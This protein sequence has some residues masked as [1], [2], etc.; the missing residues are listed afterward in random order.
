VCLSSSYNKHP[1]KNFGFQVSH[2]IPPSNNC[3]RPNW[4]IERDV[5]YGDGAE[6]LAD[7]YLLSNR[8]RNPAIIFIHGGG[9]ISGDKSA[10]LGRAKKYALAGF[11]VIAINY[12]LA[13]QDDEPTRW[14]KQ[15]EDVQTAVR[16][17]RK[18]A[19]LFGIDPNRIAAGGDSSGGHLALFLGA[20]DEAFNG[21]NPNLY[22]EYSSKVSVVLNEFGPSNLAA[23]NL[24]GAISNL[25]LIS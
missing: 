9:W 25:P 5:K 24:M 23:P 10:Y 15:L 22:G 6:Q 2:E 16:W 3:I 20:L 19:A 1:W 17:V 7:L 18:N 12:T 13:R 14:P 21:T 8:K 11:N 4:V